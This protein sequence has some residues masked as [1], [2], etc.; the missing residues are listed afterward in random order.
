MNRSN[1]FDSN[2]LWVKQ[3]SQ[4]YTLFFPI[5][6]VFFLPARAHCQTVDSLIR[7]VVGESDPNKLAALHYKLSRNYYYD[8]EDSLALVHANEAIKRFEELG[9]KRNQALAI[10]MKGNI[11][12]GSGDYAESAAQ[13][14]RAKQ[15]ARAI[16]NDTL[17]ASFGNNLGVEYKSMGYYDKALKEL[18]QVLELK[19][20]LELSTKSISATLLNIGL[21]LDL[22]GK[23]E[24]LDYYKQS[25]KLKLQLGDSLGVSKLL[26]N[27]SVIYKNNHQFDKALETIL[28]SRNY[29]ATIQD[30]TQQYIN[31]TNEA[32]ILKLQGDSEGALAQFES[33][34]KLATTIGNETYASDVN[35][36]IGALHFDQG[37]YS[38]A[39]RY[40]EKGLRHTGSTSSLSEQA[41]LYG[42]MYE[43]YR[44][45]GDHLQALN[46]LE[47]HKLFQDSILNLESTKV[48]EELRER[49]E[50]ERK[51]RMIL[52]QEAE[53]ANNKLL[54]RK[55]RQAIIS[56]TAASIT[57]LLMGLIVFLLYRQKQRKQR[58]RLQMEM[59]K[60]VG[61]LELLRSQINATLFDVP[62][63]ITATL[64][65]EEFNRYLIDPLTEREIEI[66]ESVA[67]GKTNKQVAEEMFVSE[68]TVKFH[69]KNIYM[70]LDVQN[71]TEALN[72][73]TALKIFDK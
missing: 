44:E 13:Y 29:N 55:K 53:I 23:P 33:A 31:L 28:R 41:E 36:N 40:F 56:L 9:N 63:S 73:A 72:K 17:L 59:D 38:K 35:Q 7:L 48:I 58:M 62:T 3:R 27:I 18:Y 14:Q 8:Y 10:N 21:V 24:A 67:S 34:L 16:H 66:L 25:L 1:N 42:R 70:K 69:L 2:V 50:T 19:Q 47:K 11:V 22:L 20:R 54:I 32:N 26:S 71:R 30:P 64:S 4:L 51:E 12:S 49:Y 5:M 15:L 43:A 65:K 45:L 39:V 6:A 37:R 68:N 52:E 46:A 57:M 60:Y 61:E